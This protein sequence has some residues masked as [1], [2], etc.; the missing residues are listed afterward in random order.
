MDELD[1]RILT[2]VQ[3]DLP[4]EERPFDALAR[5]LNLAP[6]EM[7][8]RLRQLAAQGLIRRVGPV[9]DSRRLGYVSTLVAARMPADRLTDVAARVSALPGVT[10]NYERR[11]AYNLW[12]TLTA[13]SAAELE[14]TLANLR[15]ETGLDG[16]YSLPAEAMYKIRVQFDLVED[17]S[18]IEVALPPSTSTEPVVL[19]GEQKE[20]VRLIQDGL[21]MEREPLAAVASRLGWPVGRIVEQIQEWMTAGVIRR[22]G[23]VVRHR[24]LGF[25]ASGMAVFQVAPARIDEAGRRLAGRSEVSHCY[26]RP[27]LPDFPYNLYA[28]VHGQSEEGVRRTV[29]GMA[30]ELRPERYDVLFSAREFK[31]A[32]MRYFV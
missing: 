23:A 21:A 25:R 19:S 10:H 13:P 22:F 4:V 1:R 7:I 28:M 14:Q 29:C 15:R 24:E 32:S 16:F 12:F 3:A 5:R 8:A 11:H 27:P 17:V 26:R 18:T 2:A 6:E 31:K 9:F 20:L 30:S